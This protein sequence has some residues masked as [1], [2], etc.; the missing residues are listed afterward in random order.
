MDLPLFSLNIFG[1]WLMR[2]WIEWTVERHYT[3]GS[4]HSTWRA[5][6]FVINS[7]HNCS[8]I[9]FVQGEHGVGKWWHTRA[10]EVRLFEREARNCDAALFPTNECLWSTLSILQ[11][12]S[13]QLLC[14]HYLTDVALCTSKGHLWS[15]V[16]IFGYIPSRQPFIR[17]QHDPLH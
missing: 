8:A 13:S 10:S 11:L 12:Q 17:S 14:Q 2:V 4:F 6:L 16:C 1:D 3:A 15:F 5:R 7:Q 9:P